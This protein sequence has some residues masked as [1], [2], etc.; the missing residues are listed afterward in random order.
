MKPYFLSL[1]SITIIMLSNSISHAVE[2]TDI[3][4]GTHPDKT[5]IVIELSQ[6]VPFK[7]FTLKQ[8]N[9][10]PNRLIVDIPPFE[11]KV[12]VPK[13][14][15]LINNIRTGNSSPE[16]GRIVFDLAQEIE[17]KNAFNI[18]KQGNKP[19]RLVIDATKAPLDITAKNTSP[20]ATITTPPLKT[21][22]N[23]KS[24]TTKSPSPK[25]PL[26]LP[27]IVIDAGHGGNDPGAIGTDKS[28][29]KDITLATAKELAKQ[30]KKTGRYRVHLTRD[31]DHYIKLY[32]RVAIARSKEADLFISL[33]ADSIHKKSVRGAS[34]YTLSNTASDAQTAKLAARENQSDL[35]AGIDL[36]HED[37]EVVD[38]LLDLAMRD[39]MNQSKF[40]AN[41]L[42]SA[43]RDQGV[44][45]LERPHRYAGFAVL[46]APDIPS[47]LI[48]MGFMSNSKDVS[49]LRTSNYR[50]KI[51][52]GI[53]KSINQYFQHVR[54]DL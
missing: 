36:T 27:L 15:P 5:R 52:T 18:K 31:T 19:D 30:L 49:L 7:A 42:V 46:K 21:Q 40:F 43:L 14:S 54:K 13:T 8:E 35:I 26:Y 25:T 29:E 39:T 23:L 28:K 38:I 47:V 20:P 48:E 34:V 11:W 9:N 6:S 22:T 4:I 50:S 33:H 32:N 24:Q 2:V 12:Q 10:T 1:I 17:I 51:S 53:V 41:T 3:R 37:K 44:R 16:S 45:T